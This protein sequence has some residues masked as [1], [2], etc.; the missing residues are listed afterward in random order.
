MT[1]SDLA[2]TSDYD[3]GL[4]DLT[5]SDLSIPRLRIRHKLGVFEDGG[6]G[7]QIPSMAAVI[8]G[9]V[10]QRVLFHWDVE[11]DDA[12]MCKSNDFATGFPNL[13]P[14]KPKLAFPWAKAKFD[15][16]DFPVDPNDGLVSLPCNACS[17]KD[18]GSHPTGQEKPWCAEQFT[19]PIY[20]AQTLDQL[21]AGEYGSALVSFQKTSLPNLKRYLGQFQQRGVGAYTQYTE[22]A[23][24]ARTRG[25]TEYCVAK[26]RALG[27]TDETE[28]AGFS[29][30]YQAIRHFLTQARPQAREIQPHDVVAGV[31]GVAPATPVQAVPVQTAPAVQHPPTQSPPPPIVVP[32]AP[33][34]Q[35]PPLGVPAVTMPTQ[36]PTPAPTTPHVVEAQI[37][38]PDDDL[39][40]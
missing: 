20:Y 38:N 26:F 40:F 18:W 13:D 23:L 24:E 5:Q 12:P 37:V 9:L 19:L 27:A 21:K 28:F 31:A 2:Q 10:R 4:G 39:P 14:K 22:I 32:P 8:L 25:Q 17:L 35:R 6:S 7:I 15:P 1:S 30:N 3:T 16:R 11:D 36:P 34:I 33:P 29:E